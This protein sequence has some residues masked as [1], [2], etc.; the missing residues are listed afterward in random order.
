MEQD[1]TSQDHFCSVIDEF[2]VWNS[3]PIN[4]RWWVEQSS[5]SVKR[6]QGS[7]RDLSHWWSLTLQSRRVK[8]M[9]V[10]WVVNDSI[11]GFQP[12]FWTNVTDDKRITTD[13]W[14]HPNSRKSKPHWPGQLSYG[15]YKKKI[16]KSNQIFITIYLVIYLIGVIMKLWL[17]MT[18]IDSFYSEICFILY[19]IHKSQ[20]QIKCSHKFGNIH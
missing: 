12:F 1:H 14:N 17:M 19:Y 18:F 6:W 3:D 8:G 10:V 2:P 5:L 9:A 4:P 7:L 15:L 13:S 16:Q 11:S 20:F